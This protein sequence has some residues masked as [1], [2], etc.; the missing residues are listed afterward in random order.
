MIILLFVIDDAE[1][2]KYMEGLS[3]VITMDTAIQ[4][5]LSFIFA[6]IFLVILIISPRTSLNIS[7]YLS[8]LLFKNK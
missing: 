2:K 6:S 4:F 3:N 8:K 1:Y 5:G 7:I